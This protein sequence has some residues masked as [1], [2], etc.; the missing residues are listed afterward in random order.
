MTSAPQVQ[1]PSQYTRGFYRSHQG[2]SIGSA[3]EIVPLVYDLL[4]PVRVLDVGCGIGTW[5]RVFQDCGVRDLTGIDGAYVQRDALLIDPARFR[6]TDLSQPFDLQQQFDLVC[7]L[8]VGEHLPPASSENF[9]ASLVKHG[10][11][12]LF[13][14]AIPGQGGT[15]HINERWQGYW[16]SLFARHGY[17]P[18]DYIRP[19]VWHNKNIEAYYAQNVILYVRPEVLEQNARVREAHQRTGLL[20]VVHPDYFR[21]QCG[22]DHW[23]IKRMLRVFPRQVLRSFAFRL[24]RLLGKKQP[25]QDGYTARI[26]FEELS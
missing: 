2:G 8:E 15:N 17:Q 3:R 5:L 13:S 14:A 12:V 24:R 20:S 22:D 23:K 1:N 18:V 6:P 7:T 11:A 21:V 19:R 16:A 25:H 4:Q 9:V 10:P 26:G